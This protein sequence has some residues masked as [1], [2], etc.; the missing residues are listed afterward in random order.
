MKSFSH[1]IFA[2]YLFFLLTACC[3]EVDIPDVEEDPSYTVLIYMAADNSMDQD[4]AYSISKIKEG[5]K[6]S[7]GT[8]VIYLDGIGNN[9]TRLFKIDNLG[10][11][12]TLKEYPEENSA[13]VATLS[14]VINETK[15]LVPSEKFGFVFWSH[16]MGWYPGLNIVASQRTPNTY[17]YIGIDVTP[18]DGVKTITFMEIDEIADAMPNNFADYIWFDVCF[19]GSVDALYEFR[20][21]ADYLIASPTEVLL[22]AEYDASGAPYDKILP[23]LFGGKDELINSCKIFHNHYSSKTSEILRSASISMIDSKELNGLYAETKSILSGKLSLVDTMAVTGIQSYHRNVSD[24]PQV[25]FDFSEFIKLKSNPAQFSLFKE[26][27]N[28]TVLYKNATQKFMG[29]TNEEFIIDP[30]KYSGLSV[31]IPLDEFKVAEPSKYYNHATAYKY[32]FGKIEWSGVY[33]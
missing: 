23:L 32:Y 17:P 4:V 14:R 10:V 25:F 22:A 20:N 31:Y 15:Q 7:K 2:I 16:S 1:F 6:K 18:N 29:G 21:K 11:E 8:T 3:S 33:K 30:N 24:I 9:N 12:T 5:A 13:S 27:L 28:K 26:Q 19:M